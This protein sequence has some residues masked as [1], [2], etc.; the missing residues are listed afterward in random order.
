MPDLFHQTFNGAFAACG[1]RFESAPQFFAKIGRHADGFLV[2]I[3]VPIPQ[4]FSFR[5]GEVFPRRKR[6]QFFDQE[7]MPFQLAEFD[8]RIESGCVPVEWISEGFK[9]FPVKGVEGIDENSLAKVLT[10]GQAKLQLCDPLLLTQVWPLV[11]TVVDDASLRCSSV[12]WLYSPD[13]GTFPAKSP[14]F[15][16]CTWQLFSGSEKS[17]LCEVHDGH[18]T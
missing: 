16:G 1:D 10:F 4:S 15:S 6:F 12:A 13:L 5:I 8:T 3:K 9:F 2:Q 17:L 18:R 7:L 14:L 11:T